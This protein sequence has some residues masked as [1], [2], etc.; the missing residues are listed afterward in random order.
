MRR[1]EVV[2]GLDGLPDSD[3]AELDATDR[4]VAV[5]GVHPSIELLAREPT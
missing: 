1:G 5:A 3:M 4:I 2:K